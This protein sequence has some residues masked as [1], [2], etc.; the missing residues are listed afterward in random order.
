M[1]GGR[2]GGRSSSSFSSVPRGG[3]GGA[4]SVGGRRS[5]SLSS[6]IFTGRTPARGVEDGGGSRV[7]RIL[8]ETK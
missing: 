6:S 7:F 5:V 4:G 8:K 2:E 1:G 3:R